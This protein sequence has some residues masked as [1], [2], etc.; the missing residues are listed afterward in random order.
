MGFLSVYRQGFA[1]GELTTHAGR[2]P[3]RKRGE[4]TVRDTAGF[5]CAD[6]APRRLRP[7]T[8]QARRLLAPQAGRLCYGWESKPRVPCVAIA[9]CRYRT[10]YPDMPDD[11]DIILMTAGDYE[12]FVAQKTRAR[13]E[14]LAMPPR[15]AQKLIKS[16]FKPAEGWMLNH[17]DLGYGLGEREPWNETLDT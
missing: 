9:S 3:A 7:D 10:H 4:C 8:R 12:A 5:L 13:M 16:G 1:L 17:P 14:F 11:P 2:L 15:E 6:F